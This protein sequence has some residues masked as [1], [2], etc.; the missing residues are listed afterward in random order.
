MLKFQNWYIFV[1]LTV[2]LLYI[3]GWSSL[4]TELSP[5]ISA[6]FAITIFLCFSMSLTESPI[7]L[8]KLRW[9]GKRKPIGLICI[10]VAFCADWAYRGSIPIFSD[11]QG[12]DPAQGV[13]ELVVGIPYVH[14]VIVAVAIFYTMYTAFLL[15][16]DNGSK[17]YAFELMFLL[18]LL[19]LNNSRGYV[20]FCIF[21]WLL[22]TVAFRGC[23]LRN[24][25]VSTVLFSVVAT[26]VVIYFISVMGNIRSGV[27][28]NDC[29]YI[30]RIAFFDN[31]PNWMPKH[32]MWTYSYVT[33]P[34]ANLNLNLENYA[35]DI[36]IKTLIYSFFPEQFSGSYIS[37][38]ANISYMVLHLNAASG[39]VN[40]AYAGG[41]YGMFIAFFVMILYFTVVK[42]ILKHFIVLETF[43]NA[44]LCFLVASLIFFN[45]FT[46]SALCY[47]PIF[48]II[49]SIYLNWMLK[50]NKVRVEYVAQLS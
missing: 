13:D 16:S 6:F 28:W 2:I 15:V 14:V 41:V 30:K 31:Y 3:C 44:V 1:W 4:N 24:L 17:R 22:M 32:F 29:S 39:F 20:V 47:I 8:V 11:Y 26:V 45:V 19:L 49:A 42:L 48:L 36:D 27:G 10:A 7:S 34:L 18:S 5:T 50:H 25:K 37:N 23:Q 9:V 12:Y 21:V 40:F 35:G 43:G 38:H 46:T 33:S